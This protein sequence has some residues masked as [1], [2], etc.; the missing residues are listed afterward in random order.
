ML[1]IHGHIMVRVHFEKNAYLCDIKY[2][3]IIIYFSFRGVPVFF[4]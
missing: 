4:I 3:N 2:L 1:Y